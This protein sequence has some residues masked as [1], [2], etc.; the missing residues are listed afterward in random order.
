[1]LDDIPVPPPRAAELR[2]INAGLA[3]A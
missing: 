1:M 3:V 2:S